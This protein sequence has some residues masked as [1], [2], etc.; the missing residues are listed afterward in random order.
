M[1]VFKGFSTYNRTKRYTLSDFDLVKQDIFNHFN[2]RKGEKLMRPEFGTSLWDLL[3][4][5]FGN[6]ISS[7]IEQE[8]RQI[9]SID[10]RVRLEKVNVSTY[11]NGINIAISLVFVP[12]NLGDVLYLKFDLENKAVSLAQ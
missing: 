11:D 4:E 8:V 7:A 9:V 10:P 3:F 2:I 1:T 12:L 5:P 6:E